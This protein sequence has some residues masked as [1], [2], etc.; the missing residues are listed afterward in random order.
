MTHRHIHGGHSSSLLIR[1]AA[2]LDPLNLTPGAIFLD[3]GCGKGYISLEAARR[4]GTEGTVYAFDIFEKGIAGLRR[5]AER[6]GLTALQAATADLTRELPVATGT[7]D[8]CLM[9]NVLHGFA[10]NGETQP[11]L[12]EIGR[13]IRPG[14]LFAVGE[15]NKEKSLMGPP[16]EERLDEAAVLAAVQPFGFKHRETRPLGRRHYLVLLERA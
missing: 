10:V 4:V 6:K 7:V 9:L 2:V 13:V 15:F 3:A 1:A 8:V 16:L 5:Q 12:T 14:G 11:V